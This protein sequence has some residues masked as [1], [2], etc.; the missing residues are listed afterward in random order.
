MGLS[1]NRMEGVLM[2]QVEKCTGCNGKRFVTCPIC[3]GTGI[4]SPKGNLWGDLGL[5]EKPRCQECQ[6]TGKLICNLCKGVG[7][8]LADT[9]KIGWP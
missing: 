4:I 6:G 7:K 9:P 3:D 8:L 5:G 1:E 2:P